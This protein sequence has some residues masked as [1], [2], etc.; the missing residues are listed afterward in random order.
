VSFDAIAPWY[1]ALE[2]VAFGN[3]LQRARVAWLNEIGAPRRALIIGEGN[4]RFLSALLRTH[5]GVAVDCV[6]SSER[7]LA[8][9][10]QQ[11]GEGGT[12]PRVHLLHADIRSWTPPQATYDLIVT[13]FLLDCFAED[14][15]AEIVARISDAA[16]AN[17]TWLLADFRHP[18][19]SLA[20]LHAQAWLFVMYRFFRFTARIEARKLIDPSP[21]VRRHGFVLE[22]QRLFRG[23]MVKSE[24]WR[25]RV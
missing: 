18:S 16:T 2:T 14:Q 6:D 5:P 22:G 15:V 4:G 1:R 21:F 10:R 24:M 11:I 17:A 20:R 9:A 3:A 7:M 8:L 12:D 25:R 19:G 13:H 23:G